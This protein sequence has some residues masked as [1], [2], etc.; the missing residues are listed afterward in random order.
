MSV[1]DMETPF[2]LYNGDDENVHVQVLMRHETIWLPQKVMAELFHTT[3]DNVSLH[4][5]NIYSE[6]E[7]PESGTAEDFSVVQNAG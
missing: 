2:L 4:L 1:L 6:G 5:K 3:P 7:L